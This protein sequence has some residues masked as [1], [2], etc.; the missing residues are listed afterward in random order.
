MIN[1]TYNSLND[2][3][4]PSC[5]VLFSCFEIVSLEILR[6]DVTGGL[7]REMKILIFREILS[8][9]ILS[10]NYPII[11]LIIEDCF[12]RKQLLLKEV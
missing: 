7:N 5:G 3:W 1:N 8:S 9:D 10:R 11:N 2:T 4:L 6:N 12:K